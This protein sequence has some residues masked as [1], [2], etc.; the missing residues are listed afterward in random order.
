MNMTP[1]QLWKTGQITAAQYAAM[2]N[3]TVVATGIA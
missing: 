2:V 3:A 1:F